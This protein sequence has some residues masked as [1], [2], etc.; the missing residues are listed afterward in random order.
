[1]VKHRIR[2]QFSNYK[3]LCHLLRQVESIQYGAL[4]LISFVGYCM[5]HTFNKA[6]SKSADN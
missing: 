6:A 3:T 4:V 1:M 5:Y 2:H